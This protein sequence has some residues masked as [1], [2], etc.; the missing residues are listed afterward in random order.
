VNRHFALEDKELYSSLLTHED[1]KNTASR[2]LAGSKHIKHFFS[3]Y[4]DRWRDLEAANKNAERFI[5]ETKEAFRL[6][7]ERL[8]HEDEDFFCVVKE[9]QHL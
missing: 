8:K 2:F 6:L 7:E 9:T 1:T 4:I 3:E 5:A